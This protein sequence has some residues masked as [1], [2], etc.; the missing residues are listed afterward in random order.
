MEVSLLYYYFTLLFEML[1]GTS[2]HY[3]VF[4]ERI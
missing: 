2:S 1:L 4:F 3:L